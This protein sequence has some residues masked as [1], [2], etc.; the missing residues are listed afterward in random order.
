[1]TGK[2]QWDYL[3]EFNG[4]FL[5]RYFG[6]AKS[7]R[8]IDVSE[9][10]DIYYYIWFFFRYVLQ[11]ETYEQALQYTDLES[12]KKYG[13]A[14]FFYRQTGGKQVRLT[15]GNEVFGELRLYEWT[16]QRAGVVM[17]LQIVLDILYNRYNYLEQIECYIRH[18]PVLKT[19]NKKHKNVI[20]AIEVMKKS[21]DYMKKHPEYD[22]MLAVHQAS[23]KEIL[24]SSYYEI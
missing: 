14:R 16:I 3:D 21:L 15:I 1:M 4:N 20:A 18:Q 11:C 2:E 13:I 24:E 9:E 5:Y 22:E 8:Q 17:Y 19:K 23:R 7:I 6:S 12:I 10:K